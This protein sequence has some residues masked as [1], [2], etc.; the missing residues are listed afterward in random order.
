MKN[1][2]SLIILCLLLGTNM[3]GQTETEPNNTS[4]QANTLLYNGSQSGSISDAD[5]VDW[6]KLKVDKGGI[7][8]LLFLSDGGPEANMYISDSTNLGSYLG[9]VS[10]G[11]QDRKRDSIIVPVLKGTYYVYINRSRGSGSYSIMSSLQV[12]QYPEDEEPNNTFDK[13]GDLASNGSVTGLIGH[14]SPTVKDYDPSDW[15]KIKVDKGGIIKLLFLSD[16]GPEANMY[17]SD[18]TN[19]GSYLG[20][21][22]FGFQDRKRDSIIVPVLKGTYYV[23]IN[24]SRGSG[25]YSIISSLQVLQ[26]PEDEEP[27]NTF[28]KAGIL[29]TNGNVTGL[30]GHYSPTIKDYDPS[31]WYKLKVDKGGI[32]K[33]LFLSDGG[34]EANMYI[35]DSTNL[36]S[37]LGQASFGFQDRKRDSIIVP[38][39]KGTYYVYINRSRGS[40]SYSI[41]SF[42][43]FPK[44]QEDMEPNNDYVNSAIFAENAAISG[45]INYYNPAM[46][47]Y[48]PVDWYKIRVN[49]K[50]F[51]VIKLESDSSIEGQYVSD[52]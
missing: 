2:Y 14:Y 51:L 32:I 39:L 24:R 9:Q 29:A 21:A 40:G 6:Y 8:K 7:I 31:D 18:S 5:I 45:L 46:K 3:V 20:Y 13:S 49:N 42:F 38:V 30:I 28:D 23:Y 36:G 44:W 50:G 35:S 16:G 25:S 47:D 12:L 27:N 48:D 52:R 34:P 43:T 1:I 33:L 19:L 17:I 11:F 41:N 15:H 22:S 10:F 26:Y 37:Y 4:E